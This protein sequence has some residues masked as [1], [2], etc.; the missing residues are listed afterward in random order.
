MTIAL[1]GCAVVLACLHA[2][3]WTIMPDVD[4]ITRQLTAIEILLFMIL[5][6]MHRSDGRAK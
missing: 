2:A 1:Y 6:R 4:P 3:Q 5:A